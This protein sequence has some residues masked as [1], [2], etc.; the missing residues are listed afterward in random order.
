MK[1]MHFNLQQLLLG[2]GWQGGSHFPAQDS[3]A[4]RLASRRLQ[5]DEADRVL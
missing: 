3:C 4:S 5:L 2:G 1:M